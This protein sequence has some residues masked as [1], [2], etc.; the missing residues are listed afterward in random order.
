MANKVAKINKAGASVPVYGADNVLQI[1]A[2]VIDEL[3]IHVGTAA[4]DATKSEILFYSPSG[5][6]TGYIAKTFETQAGGLV[7]AYSEKFSFGEQV[8]TVENGGSQVKGHVFNVRGAC[9]IFYGAQ[10]KYKLAAGDAV[11]VVDGFSTTGDTYNT[12]LRIFAYRQSGKWYHIGDGY[13]DTDLEI[14]FTSKN[15]VT[16]Y[17]QW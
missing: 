4:H 9:R 1:G 10:E 6:K 17:G 12:R 3:F 2:L 15:K 8:V 13:C 11:L 7:P 5:W 16:V 14:G